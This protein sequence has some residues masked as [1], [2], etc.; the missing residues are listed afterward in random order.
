MKRLLALCK[1]HKVAAGIHTGGIEYTQKY[2]ELGF[3]FA[4][5]G[6]DSGHMMKNAIKE[7]SLA[8]GITQAKRESTGY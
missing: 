7:L 1:K 5:L 6:S 3:N 4:A 8:K 2:L